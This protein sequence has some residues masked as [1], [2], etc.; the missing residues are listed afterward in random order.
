MYCK[1]KN[2]SINQIKDVHH[3]EEVYTNYQN[4]LEYSF[5][6]EIEIQKVHD[7]YYY[8]DTLLYKNVK[9]FLTLETIQAIVFQDINICSCITEK[10]LQDKTYIGNGNQVGTYVVILTINT[11]NVPI[12][13]H[14][15]SDIKADYIYKNKLYFTTVLS[16]EEIVSDMKTIGLLP[17][18]NLTTTFHAQ[19][20]ISTTYFEEP[21]YGTYQFN[22]EYMATSG[23]SGNAN[24]ELEYN[25]PI[26]KTTEDEEPTTNWK[27]FVIPI[28]VILLI[29]VVLCLIFGRRRYRR[30]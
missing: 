18:V 6:V 14:V 4:N 21:N 30:R 28:V 20:D 26:E 1:D 5:Y 24:I 29:I 19:N 7:S 22:V 10:K 9:S 16:A 27:D 23:E 25:K 11:Q 2:I 12:N 8:G 3:L 17:K 13:I 15:T